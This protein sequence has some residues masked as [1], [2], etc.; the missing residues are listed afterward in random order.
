MRDAEEDETVI[1]VNV[2]VTSL[3]LMSN[4]AP[5]NAVVSEM[6]KLAIVCEVVTA[7]TS[8]PFFHSPPISSVNVFGV[9][10]PIPIFV[11]DVPSE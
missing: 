7:N 2:T 1:V 9:S 8:T 4:K 10:S 6:V 5:P 3:L 11:C